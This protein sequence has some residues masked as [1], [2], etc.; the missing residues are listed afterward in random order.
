MRNWKII[1]SKMIDL[2]HCCFCNCLEFMYPTKI[3]KNAITTLKNAD[4]KKGCI[5]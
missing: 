4:N 3:L 2:L 1:I 5:F